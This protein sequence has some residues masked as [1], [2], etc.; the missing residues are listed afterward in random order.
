MLPKMVS[1]L[2]FGI[3]VKILSLALLESYQVGC[4][5]VP[6]VIVGFQKPMVP[7]RVFDNAIELAV[8]VLPSRIG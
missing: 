7:T 3:N 4:L 6:L 2:A 1:L 5:E 8:C